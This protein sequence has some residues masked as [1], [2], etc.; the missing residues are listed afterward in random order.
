MKVRISIE[1]EFDLD[2][3][4]IFID[5]DPLFEDNKDSYDMDTRV[6][7][8]VNRFAEDI[9]YMVKYDTVHDAILVEYIEE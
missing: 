8:L 7:L 9:D 3:D 2:D 1:Q 5:D 6:E 4:N